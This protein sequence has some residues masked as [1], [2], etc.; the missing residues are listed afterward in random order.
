MDQYWAERE[1][2]YADL[3]AV[4]ATQS[5]KQRIE[6]SAAL[7][8]SLASDL[9][10]DLWTK[11]GAISSLISN[12]FTSSFFGEDG[13][14][15]KDYDTYFDSEGKIKATQITG[16]ITSFYD[17]NEDFF[18]SLQTE[19]QISGFE[20][21]IEGVNKGQ[22]TTAQLEN[23]LKNYGF[24]KYF[25]GRD[26]GYWVNNGP[27]IPSGG[28]LNI[29]IKNKD[30]YYFGYNNLYIKEY[31]KPLTSELGNIEIA[32]YGIYIDSI[33]NMNYLFLEIYYFNVVII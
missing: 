27:F 13:K 33:N 16:E 6:I 26:S 1:G 8:Q 3:L 25:F 10:P 19:E 28:I 5:Q 32:Q 17:N 9:N 15:N 22:Y 12:A 2:A 14:F 30:N 4:N 29:F 7:S 11:S 24:E 20:K 23:E 18:N 21:L 31:L